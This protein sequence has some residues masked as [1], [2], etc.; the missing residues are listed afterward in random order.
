MKSRITLDFVDFDGSG[1]E[2]VIR[3]DLNPSDDV[4]DNLLKSIFQGS[5]DHLQIQ[6]GHQ[7]F[8]TNDHG[9]IDKR[10]KI[11]LRAK[12]EN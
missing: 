12:R 4:R 9:G 8:E 1:A 10:S 5:S 3:V 2:P 6:Y 11:Y 7:E